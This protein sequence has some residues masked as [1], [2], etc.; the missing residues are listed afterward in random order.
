[1]VKKGF[2]TAFTMIELIFAIVV[3]S[4]TIISLPMM[5]QV[6]SKGMESNIAQ[7]AIFAASVE[8]MQASTGYWDANSMKDINISDYSRV[9]NIN[10]DCNSSTKLRPGHINQPFHR[11]CVEETLTVTAPSN[12]TGNSQF[13]TLN[14]FAH[15]AR[16]LYVGDTNDAAGYKDVNLTISLSVTTSPTNNNIKILTA[17]VIKDPQDSN[18]TITKLYTQSA[19]I[20]EPQYYKRMF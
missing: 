14:D 8:L 11:R 4:I 1:M 15:P 7:E 16:Q 13:N 9:I 20:G 10:G 6:N 3:I 19:N 12:A 17:T 2:K 18:I 5:M